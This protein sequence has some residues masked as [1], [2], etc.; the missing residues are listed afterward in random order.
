MRHMDEVELNEGYFIL[1]LS[2]IDRIL[3]DLNRIVH[4]SKIETQ[5]SLLEDDYSRR[6]EN[7][8]KKVCTKCV[9][10]ENQC[11][12]LIIIHM[13]YLRLTIFL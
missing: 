11:N 2:T 13:S 9:M 12:A 6:I 4:Q 1:P 8:R 10:N 5:E 7:R 3:I